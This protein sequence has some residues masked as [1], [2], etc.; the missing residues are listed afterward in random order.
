MKT[1]VAR[2]WGSKEIRMV[3]L[4]KDKSQD[5]FVAGVFSPPLEH[6][7]SQLFKY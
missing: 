2:I 4:H 6:G 5:S 7:F 1:F 3:S